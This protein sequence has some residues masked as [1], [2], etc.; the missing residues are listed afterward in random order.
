MFGRGTSFY[1]WN[2]MLDGLEFVF[3]ERIIEALDMGAKAMGIS[4]QAFRNKKSQGSHRDKFNE[5][6]LQDLIRYIKEVSSQLSVVS[7]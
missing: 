1:R 7:D 2:T 5:K 3:K 4:V 6:N